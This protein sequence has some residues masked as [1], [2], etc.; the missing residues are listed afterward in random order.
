MDRTTRAAVGLL[1][2]LALAGCSSGTGGDYEAADDI[3]NDLASAGLECSGWEPNEDVV[4]AQE[5]GSCEIDGKAT[6]VTIYKDAEQRAQIR[7]AFSAFD[8]GFSVDG[9]RWTV[10]VPTRA[11]AEKV[12]DALGGEIN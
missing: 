6:T 3:R 7:E 10:N 12:R 2:A 5:D 9:G 4:G 1:A 11:L 8:S